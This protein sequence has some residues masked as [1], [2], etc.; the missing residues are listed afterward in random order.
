MRNFLIKLTAFSILGVALILLSFIGLSATKTFF[1]RTNIRAT[2]GGFGH[3]LLRYREAEKLSEIDGLFLGSSHVYRGIDTRIFRNAGLN[4]FNFGNSNQ[5]PLNSYYIL[6]N[7]LPKIRT[8]RVYVEIYYALL[9]ETGLESAIDIISNSELNSQT[10]QMANAIQSKTA[11]ITWLHQYARRQFYSLNNEVQIPFKNDSYISGGFVETKRKTNNKI[12][13]LSRCKSFIGDLKQLQYIDSI[14]KLCNDNACELVL[15]MAPVNQ[16]CYDKIMNLD[17]KNEEILNFVQ[18]RELNFINFNTPV[19]YKKMAL[20]PAI[21]WYDN[22]HLTQSG[23]EKFN[24]YFIKVL[25]PN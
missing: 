21:D 14:Q 16:D 10:F 19:N 12:T 20:D 25:S 18:S 4:C 5:T 2:T 7:Y 15:F 8:K 1:H 11:L 3:S 23:V 13:D 17:E 24:R 9:V 6:K 22:T